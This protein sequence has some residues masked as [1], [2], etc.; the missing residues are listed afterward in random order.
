M[1]DQEILE[2]F[3]LDFIRASGFSVIV[4]SIWVDRWRCEFGRLFLLGEYDFAFRLLWGCVVFRFYVR[5][6]LFL[7]HHFMILLLRD[8][9]A[10]FADNWIDFFSLHISFVLLLADFDSF[11]DFRSIF[12]FLF[13]LLLLIQLFWFTIDTFLTAAHHIALII[14]ANGIAWMTQLRIFTSSDFIRTILFVRLFK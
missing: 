7:S 13:L 10:W 12:L 8:S 6:G 5:V 3:M 4:G 1:T 11:T 14:F 9:I 2:L